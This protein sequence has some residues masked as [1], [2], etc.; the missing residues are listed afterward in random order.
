MVSKV[1]NFWL[2]VFSGVVATTLIGIHGAISH[3][4]NELEISKLQSVF[5]MLFFNGID[6]NY[7]LN[8]PR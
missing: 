4:N 2:C 5:I 3:L 7:V 6:Q 1:R 8:G